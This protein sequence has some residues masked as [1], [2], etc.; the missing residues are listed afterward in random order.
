VPIKISS[1]QHESFCINIYDSQITKNN[2]KIFYYSPITVLQHKNVAP[3]HNK[4]VPQLSVNFLTSN[5]E[6]RNKVA[7]HLNQS[8]SQQIESSQV[9]VLPYDSVRLTSKIQSPDFT[10]ID[11]WIP[12]DNALRFT[13]I[14]PTPEDCNRMRNQ[15][16]DN[17]EK[18]NH[19]RLEF[20]SQ[21]NDGMLIAIFKWI[22]KR[23]KI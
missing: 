9:K 23:T 20:K 22:R 6:V 21:F 8:L 19:L 17:P 15:I 13:L 14:C 3:I 2:K 11:E 1:V 5:Q 4:T 7:K 10:L 12:H 18:F 16:R